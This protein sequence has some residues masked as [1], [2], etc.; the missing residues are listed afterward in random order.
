MDREESLTAKTERALSRSATVK[1]PTVK[2]ALD[3]F[4]PVR[5]RVLRIIIL[6]LP[7]AMLA[8]AVALIFTRLRDVMWLSAIISAALAMFL[9]KGLMRRLKTTLDSMW[10]SGVVQEKLSV[11]ADLETPPP[12]REYSEFVE[13]TEKWLNHRLQIVLGVAIVLLAIGWNA[14]PPFRAGGLPIVFRAFSS[15]VSLVRLFFECFLAFVSGLLLWRM[16][17]VGQRVWRLGRQFDLTKQLPGHP[18]GCGGLKPIASLSLWNAFIIGIA[19]LYLGG[20]II[21]S[22][23]PEIYRPWGV[24]SAPAF[25]APLF[26]VLMAVPIIIVAVVLLPIWSTHEMM[27]ARRELIR[28]KLNQLEQRISEMSRELLRR[29]DSLDPTERDTIAKKI[30]GMRQ[31]YIDN[32]RIAVWP[33]RAAGMVS[34]LS[35][36]E[37]VPLLALTG[38]GDPIVK[39]IAAVF[40]FAT[41]PR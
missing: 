17:F 9:F 37:I 12:E 21:L 34:W 36:L 32:S 20:W 2:E 19:G 18:D 31:T 33:F 4:E 7:W 3:S 23:F 40:S 35:T 25:Y 11:P 26:W 38:L 8:V 27:V 5:S 22:D 15:P 29:A 16:I 10:K 24:G 30:E 13:A 28:G 1:V 6:F 14:W 41:Q 39:A